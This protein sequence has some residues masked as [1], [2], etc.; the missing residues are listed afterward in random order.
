MSPIGTKEEHRAPSQILEKERERLNLTRPHTPITVSS[1][2]LVGTWVNSDH[3]TR[4]LVRLMISLKAN[5]IYVHAFGACYPNPC[6]WGLVE[7]RMYA[8]TVATIPGIAFVANYKFE[9]AE[10]LLT[11]HVFKGALF[12]ESLTHF[13]D[14][15]GRADYYAMDVLTK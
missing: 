7:A 1:E 6:D 13:T 11:G 14:A 2:N 9:F 4:D 8:E 10:V 5:Q 12:V 3:D 15:S